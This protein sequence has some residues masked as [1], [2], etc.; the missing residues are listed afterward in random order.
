[1]QLLPGQSAD[2]LLGWDQGFLLGLLGSH[3]VVPK[4]AHAALGNCDVQPDDVVSQI[5]LVHLYFN[6][7]GSLRQL[8]LD[9][10]CLSYGPR[11]A[12]LASPVPLRVSCSRS[13]VLVR[14]CRWL[15][16]DPAGC[17]LAAGRGCFLG[18]CVPGEEHLAQILEMS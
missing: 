12:A 15:F 17:V 5:L 3:S 2:L 7:A 9:L 4:L 16:V 10:L 6:S 14:G 13:V 11:H 18:N 1:M 8:D